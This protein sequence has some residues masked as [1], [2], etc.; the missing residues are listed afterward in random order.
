MN[1]TIHC[2]YAYDG[3]D[4]DQI[5]WN[6]DTQDIILDYTNDVPQVVHG[7]ECTMVQPFNEDTQATPIKNLLEHNRNYLGIFIAEGKM[8]I[9]QSN[10]ICTVYSGSAN[11]GPKETWEYQLFDA[12]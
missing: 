10:N 4:F 5:V 1:D 6:P 9:L 7:V 12:E 2:G 3:E 8:F 11:S